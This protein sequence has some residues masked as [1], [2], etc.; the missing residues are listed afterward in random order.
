MFIKMNTN[1]ELVS[2][3]KHR[4]TFFSDIIWI[5][6]SGFVCFPY[7]AGKTLMI[8]AKQPEF[9][10]QNHKKEEKCLHTDPF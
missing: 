6:V 2:G 4:E 3:S 7:L 1:R 5:I 10:S 9:N 8:Y